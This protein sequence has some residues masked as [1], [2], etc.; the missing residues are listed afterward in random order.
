M[1][2]TTPPP[3]RP[4]M[5]PITSPP[6]IRVNPIRKNR[7]YG[8]GSTRPG[9]P[10]RQFAGLGDA[11]PITDV[12]LRGFLKWAQQQYP[13]AIYQQIATQIQQNIPQA[14]SGYMLG[15]WRK[16][17]RLNGLADNSDG[18]VDTADAA[19][20]TPA[21][22]GW[23]DQISQIIGTATGSYLSIEQQRQNA[24]I[25]TAQLQQAQAGRAPYPISLSSS[26]VTFQAQGNMSLGE[27]LLL[28]G[29]GLVLLKAMKVL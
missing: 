19:N 18:T 3:V 23:A 28:G 27:V 17:A 16:L 20:S 14:F 8:L 12:G 11:A 4:V 7:F 22:A 5:G 25:V 13:A 10:C 6:P 15:G 26:G 1:R 9:R 21:S 2:L 24:Q 29:I